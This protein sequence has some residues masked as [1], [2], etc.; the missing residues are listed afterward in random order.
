MCFLVH[1]PTSKL[2]MHLYSNTGTHLCACAKQEHL[3]IDVI[4]TATNLFLYPSLSMCIIC[5]SSI[6]FTSSCILVKK[7]FLP[8]TYMKNLKATT[9]PC[10]TNSSRNE[11]SSV[12]GLKNKQQCYSD[13]TGENKAIKLLKTDTEQKLCDITATNSSKWWHRL[14]ADDDSREATAKST[15][16]VGSFK[17]VPY[18]VITLQ[19]SFNLEIL[20]HIHEFFLWKSW[21]LWLGMLWNY[22]EQTYGMLDKWSVA[23]GG[24]ILWWFFELGFLKRCSGELV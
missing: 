3:S 8:G 1:V 5:F 15:K 2:W 9:S 17:H 23:D 21:C 12:V 4:Y 19:W 11:S 18:I 7:P 24:N 6:I 14:T 22:I 13:G 10:S 20:H 16:A